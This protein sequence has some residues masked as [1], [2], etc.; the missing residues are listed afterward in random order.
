VIGGG[1]P[2]PAFGEDAEAFQQLWI[3]QNRALALKSTNGA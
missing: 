3:E 1:K 2:N